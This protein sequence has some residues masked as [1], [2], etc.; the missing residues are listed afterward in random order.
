MYAQVVDDTKNCTLVAASTLS[1][2]LKGALKSTS[3]KQAAEAVGKLIAEKSLAAGIKQVIFDRN[4]F[5][6]HGR[7]QVLAEA[8]RKSGLEF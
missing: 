6:Y 8:A 7:V 3:N 2:E 1:K 5:I 4:G